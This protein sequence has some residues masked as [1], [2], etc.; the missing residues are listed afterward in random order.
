MKKQTTGVAVALLTSAVFT[1]SA[2]ADYYI[3]TQQDGNTV[4]AE[5]IAD[6]ATLPAIEFTVKLPDDIEIEDFY[7][8]SGSVFN[9]SNGHFAWADVKAPDNGTVMYSVTFTVKNGD[10]GKSRMWLSTFCKIA[11]ALQVSADSLL[12]LD[13]PTINDIY[14]SE[15]NEIISDCT[16]DEIESIMKITREIKNTMRKNN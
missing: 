16:P 1:V 7:T 3:N 4:K 8:I 12:R 14:Q 2:S 5:V 13:V 10:K 15:Y 11:E 6:S 9:E